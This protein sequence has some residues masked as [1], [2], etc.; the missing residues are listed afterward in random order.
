MPVRSLG[1]DGES[2]AA[3]NPRDQY[4]TPTWLLAYQDAWIPN[5]EQGTV[6]SRIADLLSALLFMGTCSLN[7]P[8]TAVGEMRK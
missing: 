3:P 1:S 7:A 2:C 5:D 8:F 4:S 6:A